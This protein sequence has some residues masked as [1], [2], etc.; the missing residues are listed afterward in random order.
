MQLLISLALHS[1]IFVLY[2]FSEPESV[3]EVQQQ[4]KMVISLKKPYTP[5]VAAVSKPK[6]VKQIKKTACCQNDKT[7]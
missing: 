4:K 1:S 3:K 6:P 5:P 2:G 7:N